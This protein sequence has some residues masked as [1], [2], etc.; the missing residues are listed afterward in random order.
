[1]S[2]SLKLGSP[3]PGRYG[4][5][6]GSVEQGQD[7]S[8]NSVSGD[9]EKQGKDSGHDCRGR[10]EWRDANADVRLRCAKDVDGAN[11]RRGGQHSRRGDNLPQRLP[12]Q[13]GNRGEG[14]E[15]HGD[16]HQ[17]YGDDVCRY[18]RQRDSAKRRQQ[19]RQRRELSRDRCRQDNA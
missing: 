1:M 18:A 19:Q 9:Y 10:R 4:R 6:R 8:S 5:T 17:R 7:E 15:R 12:E 13:S 16:R 2:S 14:S 3:G 11:Q